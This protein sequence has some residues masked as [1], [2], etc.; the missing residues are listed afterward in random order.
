ML[1]GKDY[2]DPLST[3]QCESQLHYDWTPNVHRTE[4]KPRKKNIEG[5][6]LW[7]DNS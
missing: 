3:G 4:P 6:Y 2:S 5:N 1:L 7:Y